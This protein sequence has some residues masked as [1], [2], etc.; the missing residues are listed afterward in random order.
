MKD[1]MKRGKTSNTSFQEELLSLQKAQMKEQEKQERRTNSL[2]ASMLEPQ[3]KIEV[4]EREKDRTFFMEIGKLFCSKNCLVN[5]FLCVL[6]NT[7]V[8]KLTYKN[9]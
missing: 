1:N 9:V 6:G 5:F 4:E 8:K 2:I 3:Q 7:T